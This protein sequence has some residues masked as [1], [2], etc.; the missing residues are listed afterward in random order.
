MFPSLFINQFYPRP[1]TPA[2]KMVRISAQEVKK[3]TKKLSDWFQ[4]YHPYGGKVGQ[5]QDIL[6]T[7]LA[8]DNKRYVG[9]NKFYEQV[10]IPKKEQYMGKMLKV[11]IV[12]TKKHCLIGEPFTSG[13]CPN[14]VKTE[15]LRSKTNKSPSVVPFTVIALIMA[16]IV[17]ILWMFY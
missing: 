6:V 8:H 10:L 9:H 16:L 15:I 3:R 7:E 13:F 2:A 5:I 14:L 1:G 4:S 11:K 12:D 17:R